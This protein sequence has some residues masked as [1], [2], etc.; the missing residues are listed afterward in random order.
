LGLRKTEAMRRVG[1]A[2]TATAFLLL[3]PATGAYADP[4]PTATDAGA[5]S[6]AP[7]AA[8]TPV[9]TITDSGATGLT[10]LA[11]TSSGYAVVTGQR[12]GVDNSHLHVYLLDGSCKVTKT[13][14][15]SGRGGRDPQDLAV[16]ADGAIWVADT[17]DSGDQPRTSVVLWKVPADGAAATLYRLTY[18]SGQ[19]PDAEALLLQ[20]DGTPLIITKGGTAGPADIYKPTAA[21]DD[22]STSGVPMA[23]VGTFTPVKTQTPSKFGSEVGP[24]TVTGGSVSKDGSKVLIRT[25]TDAYEWNIAGGDIVATVG[26]DKYKI[27]PLPNEPNGSAVAYSADGSKIITLSSTSDSQTPRQILAYTPASPAAAGGGA[28]SGSGAVKASGGTSWFDKLSFTDL[29]YIIGVIGIIGVLMII[30]GI[31]GIRHSRKQQKLAAKRARVAEDDWDDQGYDNNRGYDNQGYESQGYDNPGYDGRGYD[32]QAGYGDQQGGYDQPGYDDGY[33]AQGGRASQGGYGDNGFPRQQQ[34]SFGNDYEERWDDR[35]PA[36]GA[37]GR[38]DPGHPESGYAPAGD[39][40]DAG[41]SDSY[42]SGFAEDGGGYDRRGGQQQQWSDEPTND[43]RA[44]G[45]QPAPAQPEAPGG[46]GLRPDPRRGT[47]RAAAPR[48]NNG[49]ADEHEGFGDL[50]G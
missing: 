37:P 29:T 26:T 19:H 11:A 2:F 16:A 45:G 33:S 13:L 36:G 5:A 10:G 1:L 34:Q 49:W 31:V 20:P 8:G 44:W 41:Y 14:N 46:R 42:G 27:T 15:F 50:R 32:N 21:L 40:Y 18:P 9:C 38:R 17:G 28:G 3:V 48:P 4:S 6:E 47:G 35:A 7:P 24:T 43:G 23:K 30:G 39:G 25:L 22:K 12:A